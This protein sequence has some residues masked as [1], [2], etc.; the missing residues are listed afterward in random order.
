M[1][2]LEFIV[3]LVST[4][5]S[6][7]VVWMLVKSNNK[8]NFLLSENRML[9]GGYANTTASSEETR[10]LELKLQSAREEIKL[11]DTTIAA[12]KQMISIYENQLSEKH[13]ELTFAWERIERLNNEL[14]CGFM[15]HVNKA[16]SKIQRELDYANATIQELIITSA[17]LDKQVEQAE[18]RLRRYIKQFTLTKWAIKSKELLSALRDT[19][20]LYIQALGKSYA[21]HH[22]TRIMGNEAIFEKYEGK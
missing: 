1:T 21:T 12:Q 7:T 2:P 22:L 17:N 5:C 14:N 15:K 6:G 4:A 18:E 11:K 3:L 8:I 13:N 20:D 10:I 9:R 19:H 16:E